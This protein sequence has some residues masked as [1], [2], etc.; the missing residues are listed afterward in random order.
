MA[1]PKTS[2]DETGADETGADE[3]GATKASPDE[4]GADE[5]DPGR[6]LPPTKTTAAE[7]G[8]DET[9]AMKASSDETGA[10]E[11]DP[12]RKRLPTK[13][14]RTNR[15]SDET[16]RRRIVH[17]AKPLLAEVPFAARR[18]HACLLVFAFVIFLFLGTSAR[19]TPHPSAYMVWSQTVAVHCQT[20]HL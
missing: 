1:P 17:T 15:T 11:K 20:I 8:A 19:R 9:G 2:A 7:N 5:S 6:K 16:I 3:N 4:K 10:D 14:A 12:R 13:R 18:L